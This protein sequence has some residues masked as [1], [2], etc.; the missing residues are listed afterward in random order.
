LEKSSTISSM[1]NERCK[2]LD[3]VVAGLRLGDP[4]SM[5]RLE[6]LKDVEG[7]IVDGLRRS[8]PSGTG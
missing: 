5:D 8:P 7:C 4:I 1:S 2:E 6:G 3:A